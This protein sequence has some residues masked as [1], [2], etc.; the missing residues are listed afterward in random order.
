M[1][2]S[3]S[4]SSSAPSWT[5]EDLTLTRAAGSGLGGAVLNQGQLTLRDTTFTDNAS[6]GSSGGGAILNV[7]TLLVERSTFS[8]NHAAS[9]GAV[10]SL[11]TSVIDNS[12]FYLNS[13][14]VGRE[15]RSSPAPTD[16]TP[17]PPT[18]SS[19]TLLSLRVAPSPHSTC[20]P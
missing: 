18:R 12:T 10:R 13:A 11:G 2:P 14:T 3:F 7:G 6:T 16:T 19:G 4:T 15:V 8:S 5:L 1:R 17:G 9:G 20:T